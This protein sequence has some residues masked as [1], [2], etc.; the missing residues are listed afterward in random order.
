MK[1]RHLST[2]AHGT[3]RGTPSVF[4]G[5][6]QVLTDDFTIKEQTALGRIGSD[7]LDRSWGRDDSAILEPGRPANSRLRNG[8]FIHDDTEPTKNASRRS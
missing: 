2:L 1:G 3:Y 5:A 4:K 6:W 8:G 7:R